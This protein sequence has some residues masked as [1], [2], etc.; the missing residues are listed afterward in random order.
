MTSLAI[1]LAVAI[2]ALL[3][4]AARDARAF[5]NRRRRVLARYLGA[6]VTVHLTSG[7]TL[8][9]TVAS[10]GIDAVE[11]R[12]AEHLGESGSIVPLDGA[13]VFPVQRI[14]FF[15]VLAPTGKAATS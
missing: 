1:I 7:T 8:R 6:R 5:A 11:L 2:G 13:Q 9:G 14:D 4:L 15:Q 10:V 3:V 12:A